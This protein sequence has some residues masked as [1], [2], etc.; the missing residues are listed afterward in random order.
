VN[1]SVAASEASR[2]EPW[3]MTWKPGFVG[4]V[5]LWRC[6]MIDVTSACAASSAFSDLAWTTIWLIDP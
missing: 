6:S 5:T 3:L 4:S 2:T 1:T